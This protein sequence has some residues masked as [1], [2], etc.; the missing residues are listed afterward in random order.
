MPL[1]ADGIR[2]AG[3]FLTAA[4]PV[5]SEFSQNLAV[6]LGPALQIIGDS[7]LRIGKALGL[8]SED[9]EN[10]DGAMQALA[11]TLDLVVTAIEAVA[12]GISLV[13][14]AI[15]FLNKVEE[16][17]GAA[18]ERAA[19]AVGAAQGQSLLE[20]ATEGADP[21]PERLQAEGRGIFGFQ[22]GGVVPGSPSQAT[23][24][25]LH[26]GEEVANPNEGQAVIIDGQRFAVREAGRLAAAINAQ[27]QRNFQEYTNTLAEALG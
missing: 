3:E 7:L 15:E 25:I 6:T 2:I 23:P 1:L 9:A 27:T 16:S 13:A 5:F 8:V 26:G 21:N 14:D 19:E 10:T 4:A 22:G 17:I 18:G 24:A 20:A 11:T 12:V